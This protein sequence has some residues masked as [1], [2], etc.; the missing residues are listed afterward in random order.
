MTEHHAEM[1]HSST[2]ASVNARP[3]PQHIVYLAGPIEGQSYED[4]TGWREIFAERMPPEVQCLSPMRGK[5]HLEDSE[6]IEND[7]R[8]L[9][10]YM[11]RAQDIYHRDRNDI[12]RADVVVF[13]F[14]GVEEL[15]KGSLIEI[16]W[17]DAWG[18]PIVTVIHELGYKGYGEPHCAHPLFGEATRAFRTNT[19]TSAAKAVRLILG[20]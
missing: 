16:G 11:S 19:L 17:A 3:G 20:V 5:A 9:S 4:A 7:E 12:R 10:P 8:A 2:E 14:E 1:G 13:N 18:K 15:G 6:C